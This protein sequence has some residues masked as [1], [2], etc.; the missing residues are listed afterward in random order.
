MTHE[1][2]YSGLTA[3]FREV[4]DDD[5]IDLRPET[6]ADNIEG[7]DSFSNVTLMIAVEKKFGIRLTTI[8][9]DKLCCVGD[10]VSV[11]SRKLN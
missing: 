6:A 9:I 5:S 11:I 10:L 8:E 3:V 4:F 2:L 1:K 7:W